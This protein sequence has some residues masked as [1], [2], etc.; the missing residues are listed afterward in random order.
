MKTTRPVAIKTPRWEREGVRE[1]EQGGWMN[2]F[3]QRVKGA[4]PRIWPQPLLGM[5]VYAKKEEKEGG[6]S[7]PQSQDPLRDFVLY[8]KLSII[9]VS[10][11]FET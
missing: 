9:F 2:R 5:A 6:V 3:T 4:D 7:P 8:L 1:E 10:T 11:T